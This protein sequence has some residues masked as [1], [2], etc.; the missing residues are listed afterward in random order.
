VRT[1]LIRIGRRRRFDGYPVWL[2]AEGDHREPWHQTPLA[3]ALIPDGLYRDELAAIGIGPD[4]D[5]VGAPREQVLGGSARPGATSVIGRFLG[6]ALARGAVKEQWDVIVRAGDA[7]F[8]LHVEDPE[9]RRL[10][11]EL[12]QR[13]AGFLFNSTKRPWSR[14][15]DGASLDLPEQPVSWHDRYPLRALIVVS[16]EAGDAALQAEDEVYAIVAALRESERPVEW[17]VERRPT[18]DELADLL[19][20]FRPHVLHFIGHSASGVLPGAA[21]DSCVCTPSAGRPG[22]TPRR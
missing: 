14:L 18:M 4:D 17:H 15:E 8:L 13:T 16:S 7:R 22:T 1:V 2:Y 21:P 9:L 5:I 20:W 6:S 19:R 11:W 10:P 3:E 12:M